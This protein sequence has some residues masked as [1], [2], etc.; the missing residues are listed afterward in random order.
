MGN[1]PVEKA[2]ASLGEA[3]KAARSAA[4]GV[5]KEIERAGI[6]RSLEDVGREIAR[7]TTNVA[8]HLGTE[9]E[10]LGREIR[11]KAEG[12]AAS[13][14]NEPAPPGTSPGATQAGGAPPG[15]TT[16]SSGATQAGPRPSTDDDRAGRGE[17]PTSGPGAAPGG[18]GVRIA[19]D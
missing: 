14:A 2:K 15:P 8:G 13:G 17:P 16:S 10:E 6:A 1:D 19:T 5:K 18:G 9:L 4:E 12:T 7:A 11:L 3:W